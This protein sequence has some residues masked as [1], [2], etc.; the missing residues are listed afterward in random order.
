MKKNFINEDVLWYVTPVDFIKLVRSIAD[1]N[2]ETIVPFW[3]GVEREGGEEFDF[4]EDEYMTVTA[5]CS[6]EKFAEICDELCELLEDLKTVAP[7]RQKIEDEDMSEKD[8]V[9]KLG[10]SER[11]ASNWKMFFRRFS[12]PDDREKVLDE[13]ELRIGASEAAYKV[14]IYA[15]RSGR[16]IECHAPQAIVN[17]QCC[18][19]AIAYYLHRCHGS[20]KMIE[21]N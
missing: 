7:Y 17:Y 11:T 14:I 21:E 4:I 5:K 12:N 18:F 20:H 9:E 1:E 3:T 8:L 10:L 13:A 15:L 2:N 16:I 6:D 19:F